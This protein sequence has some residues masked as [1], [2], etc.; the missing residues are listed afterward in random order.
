MT[1]GR[2]G[3]AVSCE[4]GHDLGLDRGLLV[5]MRLGQSEFRVCDAARS[6]ME[7]CVV[8]YPPWLGT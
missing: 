6:D 3:R 1:R 7:C 4:P 8:T 5:E 2:P